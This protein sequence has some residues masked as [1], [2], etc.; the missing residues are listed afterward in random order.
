MQEGFISRFKSP[1]AVRAG[2]SRREARSNI[3]FGGPVAI[4]PGN[5]SAE[6]RGIPLEIGQIRVFLNTYTS[7]IH[8][9]HV[10]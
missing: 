4:R 8:H 10:H 1:C 9:I 6:G 3:S 7:V 2:E 5:T